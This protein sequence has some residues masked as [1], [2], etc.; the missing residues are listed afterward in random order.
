MQK[1]MKPFQALTA[2]D[3]MS[4]PVITIP[5]EMSLQGAAQVLARSA[6][7]GAPVVDTSGRCVGVLCT[8][9]FMSWAENREPAAKPSHK[10][11][12]CTAWQVPDAEAFAKDEVS[13]YMTSDP[14]TVFPDAPLHEL[15]RMMTDAHIHR[16]IVIDAQ[17]RPVGIVTSTDILALVAQTSGAA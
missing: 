9:D 12:Y 17:G 13:R 4:D 7:S 5:E 8:T 14:V 3:L 15:A 6:I 11:A 2:G 16:I 10:D 1:L